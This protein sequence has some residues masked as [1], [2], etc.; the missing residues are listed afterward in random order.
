MEVKGKAQK[1]QLGNKPLKV[2][3]IEDDMLDMR[4]INTVLKKNPIYKIDYTHVPTMKD[5]LGVLGT[6]ECDLVFLDLQLPDG[7]GLNLVKMVNTAVP[8]K[9]VI[10]LS[11]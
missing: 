7:Y 2:L 1:N 4:Y 8:D 9:P 10:I 3:H 6:Q 11:G 5:A